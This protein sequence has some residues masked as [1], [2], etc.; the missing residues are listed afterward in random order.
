MAFSVVPTFKARY[1]AAVVPFLVWGSFPVTAALMLA[2]PQQATA[3]QKLKLNC[4]TKAGKC[5][6]PNERNTGPKKY[7]KIKKSKKVIKSKNLRGKNRFKKVKVKFKQ[8]PNEVRSG[9]GWRWDTR[10][11]VDI[12]QDGAK[13]KNYIVRG[14][15]DVN[16]DNVEIDNVDVI[17][18]DHV[19]FGIA[20]RHADNAFIKNTRIG[21]ASEDGQISYGIK[22]IYGDAHN[23]KVIKT[24]I[25]GTKAGIEVHRGII[26]RNYIHDMRYRDGDHVDGILSS[27]ESDPL[28]IVGNTIIV[29]LN[30]TAAIGIQ[31]HGE[32]NR[33]VKNNLLAGGGYTLYAAGSNIKVIGNRF[34]KI[35][36]PKGGYWG[37]VTYYNP[38]APGN[39]WSD[40]IWDDT[41]QKLH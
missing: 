19:F 41:G 40:N 30:Q 9:Q 16:A 38:G 14:T 37:P 4:A 28:L 3:A 34:S 1:V 21:P 8:I 12:Y 32:S 25:F 39:V 18:G 10:G 11:W 23:M 7:I 24:E 20:L 22:D 29:D 31:G 33:T 6:Y 5:G 13:F 27:G 2:E 17:T 35:I 15:V 36:W 26:K